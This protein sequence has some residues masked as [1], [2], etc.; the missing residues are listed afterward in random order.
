MAER[1]I[2]FSIADEFGLEIKLRSDADTHYEDIAKS[3]DKEKVAKTLC[4]EALGYSVDDM[5]IIT[6][7]EYDEE[8][9]DEEE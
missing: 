5:K 8:F 9:G 6:P 3:V 7:E 4:L 1:R 2:C